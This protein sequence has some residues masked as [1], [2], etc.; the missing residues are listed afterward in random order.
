MADLVWRLLIC[1]AGFG[2][3]QTPNLKAMMSSA[4]PQRSGGASGIVATARLFGQANGAA[5]VAVCFSASEASGPQ[6]ALWLG[7][8][9]ATAASIASLL[10]LRVAKPKPPEI[11]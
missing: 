8:A 5:L 9:F 11:R 6:L 2:F 10:R 4:P 7:S 3:F 1:G